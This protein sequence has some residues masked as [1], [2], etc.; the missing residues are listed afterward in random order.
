MVTRPRWGIYESEPGYLIQ[1][2]DW[3]RCCGFGQ[4]LRWRS[5]E[6]NLQSGLRLRARSR[7]GF[8]IVE[9]CCACS[10]WLGSSCIGRLRRR[11]CIPGARKHLL[12]GLWVSDLFVNS[13]LRQ[14]VKVHYD[15]HSDMISQ[16]AMSAR[17]W[18]GWLL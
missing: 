14:Y 3:G 9:V 5:E 7:C 6:Y 2:L 18:A 10:G 13:V 11:R 16:S 15:E 8:V 4:H 1:R 12:E 17:E